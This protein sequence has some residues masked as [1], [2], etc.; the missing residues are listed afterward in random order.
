MKCMKTILP[1]TLLLLVLIS[2]AIIV[3]DETRL[4]WE[5]SGYDLAPGYR[6]TI[7]LHAEVSWTHDLALA[8]IEAGPVKV[9]VE[10][11]DTN[12]PG[13]VTL[14]TRVYVNNRVRYSGDEVQFGP[15]S[16]GS[17]D[18]SVQIKVDWDGNGEVYVHG[19]RVAAFTIENPW[20]I[21]QF[22]DRR[23][24]LGYTIQSSIVID[25]QRLPPPSSGDSNTIIVQQPSENPQGFD[26]LASLGAATVVFVL[27]L[28]LG[29]GGIMLL[30]VFSQA[31]RRGW[32]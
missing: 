24:G 12:P 10:I 32:I 30:I 9:A 3:A 14:G 2:P 4:A 21:Q 20:D 11:F 8:A 22:T 6:Y 15:G 25:Y 26:F 13:Y 19:R 31:R 7:S 23:S 27:I 16:G 29:I 5:D 17:Y 1:I 28:L 18:I